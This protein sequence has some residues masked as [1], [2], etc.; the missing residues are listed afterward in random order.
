MAD[1]TNKK[2]QAAVA[3]LGKSVTRDAEAILGAAA[4]IHSEAVDTARVAEQIAAL[5]V[6]PASV[7]ETRELAKVMDGVSVASA[8]YAS[9]SDTTA[10]MAAA[11]VDQAKASHDGIQEAVDRSPVDVSGLNRSWVTP[12]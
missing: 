7:A 4:G 5:G 10:R 3:A 1:I 2:L 12:E 8:A 9:A 11:A 6:D